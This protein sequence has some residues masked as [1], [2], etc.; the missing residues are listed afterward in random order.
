MTYVAFSADLY[1]AATFD[2]S[3]F[4]DVIRSTK[5][6]DSSREKRPAIAGLFSLVGVLTATIESPPAMSFP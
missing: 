3:H 5:G 4:G 2:S 6:F 1:L